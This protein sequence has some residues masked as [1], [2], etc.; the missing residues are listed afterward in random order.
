MNGLLKILLVL[1]LVALVSLLVAARQNFGW[2]NVLPAVDSQDLEIIRRTSRDKMDGQPVGTKLTWRNL[3]SGNHGQV[4]L[5]F[6]FYE[7]GHEC[8]ILR[9]EGLIDDEP[10]RM[11]VAL[12]FL[13]ERGWTVMPEFWIKQQLEKRR[14]KT[15]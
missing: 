2:A 8:R 5:M 12:C 11:T 6:R 3:E 9:H 4:A 7:Q 13:D 14:K 10:W 1:T 15:D